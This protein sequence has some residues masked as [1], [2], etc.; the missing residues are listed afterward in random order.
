MPDTSHPPFAP[1]RRMLVGGMAAS[2]ALWGHLPRAL[3]RGSDPRLLVV[4]L[5]GGLDGLA[6]AAPVGDPAYAALH[7][8]L[9]L[10]RQGANA[11]LPLDGF[12]V[13]NPALAF[14]HDL[15]RRRQAL[16]AH[17]AATPYRG[18]SHFDAQDVLESG[19]GGVGRSD[20]GWLNRALALAGTAGRA[21]L[22]GLAAD[23][24]VPLIMRGSAPVVSWIPD[25]TRRP[26]H[27]ATADRLADLY[28][29]TDPALAKALSKGLEIDAM[30]TAGAAS[31]KGGK[32]PFADLVTTARAAAR[33]LK[34]DTGPR[35]GAL[36]I[37]GWD[38]HA[39]EGVVAG[40]LHNRLTGLDLA[41]RTLV[42]DLGPVWQQTVVLLLTEFGRTAR[43]NGTSGTDHGTA[44]V[45]FVL[46]GSI[47]GGRVIADWPGLAPAQLYE[48]RDLKPT[49]DLRALLKG[50]LAEQLAIPA[51]ALATKVFPASTAI[52]PLQGLVA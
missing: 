26:L 16:I 38:T 19:L 51:S 14:V 40:R 48:G 30:T 15:Y 28:A 33:L 29:A 17:A 12:F 9:A 36:S 39:N 32:Q 24:V 34:S 44:T 23:A 37:G 42:E 6:V 46:G 20:D 5:R 18:R 3:A 52:S 50:V 45:A 8:D 7:G 49:Q 41:L 22:Q 31:A 4:V 13:L 35:V 2:L 1:T 21:N 27:G 10:A 47:K 25:V 43:L 11:G